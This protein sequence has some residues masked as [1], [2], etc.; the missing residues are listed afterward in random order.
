MLYIIGT[1]VLHI[2][3]ADGSLCKNR[4]SRGGRGYD[5]DTLRRID[6]DK[7]LCGRCEEKKIKRMFD[8]RREG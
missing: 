5:L 4:E 7:P 1:N 6:R 3:D 8:K 2:A